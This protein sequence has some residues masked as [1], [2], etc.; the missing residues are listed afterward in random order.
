MQFKKDKI[1]DKLECTR[2][3]RKNL[4]INGEKARKLVY[5]NRAIS[6]IPINCSI[7]F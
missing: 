7:N 5:N 3:V 4:Q 1:S 2:R 6:F